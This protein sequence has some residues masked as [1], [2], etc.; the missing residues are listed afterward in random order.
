[1]TNRRHKYRKKESLYKKPEA[2]DH[3]T[4]FAPE[5][6]GEDVD[7]ET[8]EN[9]LAEYSLTPAAKADKFVSLW[10][11]N[12]RP[13]RKYK[14]FRQMGDTLGI[15]RAYA[16][17]K[18]M[19]KYYVNEQEWTEDKFSF[20]LDKVLDTGSILSHAGFKKFEH[21]YEHGR[22]KANDRNSGMTS[23]IYETEEKQAK[24]EDVLDAW[25][26]LENM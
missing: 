10:A 3:R 20:V 18:T 22:V 19:Y 24:I 15:D 23:S 2:Q 11:K 13:L 14:G 26:K 9:D 1:M 7:E 6:L 4:L 17:V 21:L 8:P 5:A 12:S 25:D 16:S